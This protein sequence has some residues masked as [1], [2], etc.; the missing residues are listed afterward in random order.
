MSMEATLHAVADRFP[1]EAGPVA[2]L[3]G[4]EFLPPV[5]EFD[6]R[7][8]ELAGASIGIVYCA[9]H[10]AQPQ[11]ERYA[12]KH[13][14]AL[15]AE[16]FTIDMHAS[17]LPPFDVLYLAGGSPADL[18]D[19]L[20]HS[21]LWPEVL[22]RWRAGGVLAGSSAGAM[23]LCTKTLTPT[24]GARAPTIWT[25]GVGPV[26]GIGIAAHATSRP[27]AWLDEVA[28]A[29]PVPLLALGDRTGIILRHGVPFE[30]IGEERVWLV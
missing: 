2:L 7:L 23:V 26:D 18:L 10:R 17:K 9:D 20:R 8:I 3:S 4:D 1:N 30:I 12:R 28:R 29:A 27:A 15:N 25:D 24:P 6:R 21:E 11:S 5:R 19:H 14:T 22:R 16:P 13:F